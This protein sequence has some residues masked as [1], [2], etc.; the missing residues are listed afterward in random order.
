MNP[1]ELNPNLPE[2]DG[3]IRVSG[4]DGQV[5]IF[6]D[7]YGIPHVRAQS[8]IGAYF[9]QGFV[10][11]QDRLWQMEYDRLRGSGRWA[12]VAGISAREHDKTVRRF[13]LRKSAEQ[14][15]NGL[16]GHTQ[17]IFQAYAS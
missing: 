1:L 3:T 10:T 9:G 8:T 11:A 14:D 12:E 13:A 2:L 17:E 15:Y 5:E 7:S 4:L 6:R 16:D